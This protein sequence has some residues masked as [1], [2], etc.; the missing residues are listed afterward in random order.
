[1][2]LSRIIRR[3]NSPSY[4]IIRPTWLTKLFVGGDILCFV[5]QGGGAGILVASND[6]AG[7]KRGE[8]IILGGLILQLVIFGV[9][10]IVAWVWHRRLSARPTAASADVSWK[11]LI[12]I[13]YAA[14]I[15]IAVRNIFR[16]VEY[17]MGQVRLLLLLPFLPSIHT[18]KLA[19]SSAS[20]SN[21]FN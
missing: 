6:A 13:L 20:H 19:T 14:S 9:F 11:K 3:T 17:A 7:F 2:I 10:V 12:I 16:A 21:Q 1:M 5:V 18:R 8:N 4:S 15:C